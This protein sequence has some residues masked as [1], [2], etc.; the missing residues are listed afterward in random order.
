MTQFV[1]LNVAT[2]PIEVAL[3]CLPFGLFLNMTHTFNDV[4]YP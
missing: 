1:G 4:N 2:V 3:L